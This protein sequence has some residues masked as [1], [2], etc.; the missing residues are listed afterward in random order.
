MDIEIK[1]SGKWI[2][3]GDA[4]VVTHVEPVFSDGERKNVATRYTIEIVAKTV[5]EVN[6]RD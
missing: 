3:F 6:G 2:K 5:S 1:G 4:E